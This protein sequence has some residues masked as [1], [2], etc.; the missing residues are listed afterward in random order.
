MG[1]E[2]AIEQVDPVIEAMAELADAET[3][4]EVEDAA[5]KLAEASSDLIEATLDAGVEE[6]VLEEAEADALEAAAEDAL[7][8]VAEMTGDDEVA[9]E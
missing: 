2:K 5:Y 3:P 6:G 1:V 8:G 9:D 4:A 7:E